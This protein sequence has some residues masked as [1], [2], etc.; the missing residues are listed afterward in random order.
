MSSKMTAPAEQ[1]WEKEVRLGRGI[2]VGYSGTAQDGLRFSTTDGSALTL[3][4]RAIADL[5]TTLGSYNPLLDGSPDPHGQ[6]DLDRLADWLS[7]HTR[8]EWNKE[9]NRAN[10]VRLH[11]VLMGEGLVPMGVTS[12]GRPSPDRV[13]SAP[14]DV[15]LAPF[16][17]KD[18]MYMER[19]HIAHVRVDACSR[20]GDMLW[21][22]LAVI[23]TPELAFPF[24]G[25]F[26]VGGKN[27][28]AGV[29]RGYLQG[30]YSLVVAPELVKDCLGLA[31]KLRTRQER[32][33]AI[34][35]RL[36]RRADC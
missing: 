25:H 3:D 22:D 19:G 34:R 14:T 23:D 8:K 31:M 2:A 18:A 36:R 4:A 9:L 13:A 27:D 30:D 33:S 5:L 16:V 29:G 35:G 17:G 21:I 6:S 1:G 7:N 11:F 28:A 20:E 10:A 26:R 12:S 15:L 24:E 32:V